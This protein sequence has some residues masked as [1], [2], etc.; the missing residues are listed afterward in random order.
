MITNNIN[1]SFSFLH[2]HNIVLSAKEVDF[3]ISRKFIDVR[4]LEKIVD[5]AL[6]K[7]PDDEYLL[8][9]A[10]D[11]LLNGSYLKS[12]SQY[13]EINYNG[14]NRDDGTIITDDDSVND[15]WRYIILMWLFIHRKNDI[16]DYDQINAVY[17]SFDYPS[18]MVSFVNYMPAQEISKKV[19]YENI[20]HNWQ[21]Y[22]DAN[23]YLIKR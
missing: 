18:D 22:L 1:I 12:Y 15:K 13:L 4:E 3:A 9:I 21:R 5:T 10:L 2:E 6:I 11:I 23:R 7:F 17:A 20:I 8:G 14:E 19:G 16:T